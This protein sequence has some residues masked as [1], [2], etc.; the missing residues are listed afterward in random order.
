PLQFEI[1]L[2][3]EGLQGRIEFLGLFLLFLLFFL[4]FCM[5]FAQAFHKFDVV[6]LI[7]GR[8][9]AP[10]NKLN[11]ILKRGTWEKIRFVPQL[12]TPFHEPVEVPWAS[13][14]KS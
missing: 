2:K 11:E 7:H 5:D 10:E 14:C 3:A 13:V 12:M 1:F 4:G 9:E 6:K 8:E